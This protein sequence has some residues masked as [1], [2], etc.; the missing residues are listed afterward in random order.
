[1]ICVRP[2]RLPHATVGCGK[3]ACCVINKR[4][5]WVARMMLESRDHPAA[6]FITLTYDEEHLP[7]GANLSPRDLQ[8]FFKRLRREFEVARF[9]YF[10][11]GEYGERYGRPHYHAVIYCDVWLESGMVQSVWDKGFVSLDLFTE[12]R[13]AYIAGYVEKGGGGRGVR[14]SDGRVSEFSRMSLRPGI[15]YGA[16]PAIAYEVLQSHGVAY[17]IQT[18]DIP[19]AFR[20]NGKLWPVGDYLKR[21]VR[22]MA[23]IDE[24]SRRRS[25]LLLRM[26]Q[27]LLTSEDVKQREKDRRHSYMRADRQYRES[28]MKEKL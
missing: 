27:P 17:L 3:C 25:K 4:R 23:G 16:A 9:R 21:K 13:A 12:S 20:L 10:A 26:Q 7:D 22:V 18:G 14:R 2:I 11:V 5:V 28:K 15:G 19:G 24:P 8:L 6:F 1:M